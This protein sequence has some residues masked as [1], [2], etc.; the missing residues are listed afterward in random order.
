MDRYG[1]ALNKAVKKPDHR[2]EIIKKIAQNRLNTR[3]PLRG[4]TKIACILD[5]YEFNDRPLE[6]IQIR[7]FGIPNKNGNLYTYKNNI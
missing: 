7:Q 5:D 1:I 4:Q 6:S 3:L 2:L